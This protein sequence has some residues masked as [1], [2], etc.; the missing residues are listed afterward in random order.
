MANVNELVVTRYV[1]REQGKSAW[2]EA[3]TIGEA[4]GLLRQADRAGFSARIYAH[5]ADGRCLTVEGLIEASDWPAKQIPGYEI[6]RAAG[7]AAVRVHA[8]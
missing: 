7:D 5:T 3:Q 1:V 8:D 2:G 4:D 6:A